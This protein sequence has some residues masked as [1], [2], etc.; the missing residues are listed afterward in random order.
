MCNF[1]NVSSG[2]SGTTTASSCGY[3]CT[4]SFWNGGL[5]RIC[6]D[7]YGNI[8][9][10]QSGCGCNAGCGC[11]STSQCGSNCGCG[12]SNNVNNGN[13]ENNN[14]GFTCVTFCGNARNTGTTAN[15]ST[16]NCGDL[17]YARQYGLLPYSSCPCSVGYNYN[18]TGSTN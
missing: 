7:C 11:S 16:S 1:C 2:C 12:C 6:R 4:Q 15:T 18:Y 10:R 14:G 9:V 8:R 13:S 5:Q 3:G 17:Y